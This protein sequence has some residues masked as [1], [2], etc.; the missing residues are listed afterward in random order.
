MSDA[1]GSVRLRG[2]VYLS[3][4]IFMDHPLTLVLSIPK[5]KLKRSF[6]MQV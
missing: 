1:G 6:D 4:M 5:L 2:I 3:C